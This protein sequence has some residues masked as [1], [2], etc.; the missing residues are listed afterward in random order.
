ML[1]TII[2]ADE[3]SALLK[4]KFHRNNVPEAEREAAY[5]NAF[6]EIA[7]KHHILGSARGTLKSEIGS[8]L[9][10]RPRKT[11]KK[12]NVPTPKKNAI[13]CIF[14][15]NVHSVEFSSKEGITF[16]FGKNNDAIVLF[17]YSGT[18]QPGEKL[19]EEAARCAEEFFTKN[20]APPPRKKRPSKERI[21][22]VESSPMHLLLV[23]DDTYEACFAP[24]KKG[25][26]ASIT[27]LKTP[28][29]QRDVPLELMKKARGIATAHFRDVK[30]LPLDLR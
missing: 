4:G 24:G 13:F 30:T 22:Q 8:I 26:T 1:D 7:D 5:S 17:S 9:A 6:N 28:C 25:V 29:R 20:E 2:L 10:K 11:R 12:R 23:I 19:K 27:K 16:K 3:V 18:H 15:S 14:S 21:L